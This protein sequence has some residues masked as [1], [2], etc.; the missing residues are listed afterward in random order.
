MGVN[1][2]QDV[3]YLEECIYKK[4]PL[5]KVLRLFI[6]VHLTVGLNPKQFE[7]IKNEI[8]QVRNGN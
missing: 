3:A 1:T 7:F 8:Y 4:E 5:S 2:N 6:V